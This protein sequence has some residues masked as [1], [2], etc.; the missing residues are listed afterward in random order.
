MS[1]G[2]YPDFLHGA[3]TNVEPMTINFDAPVKSPI[4][5]D[6]FSGVVTD[7]NTGESNFA[8]P[9]TNRTHDFN[10]PESKE[11]IPAK[12]SISGTV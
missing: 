7:P 6:E 11:Y 12:A 5:A 8:N 9:V 10:S 2:L 1:S 3:K 4:K